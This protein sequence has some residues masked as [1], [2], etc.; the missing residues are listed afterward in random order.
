MSTADHKALIRRMLYEVIVEG[1][2]ALMDE[3]VAPD[4][5]NHNVVGTGEASHSVGVD[6]FRQETRAIR[7]AQSDIAIDVAHLLADGDYVIAHV[8]SRSSHTGEFGGIPPTGK[9]IEVASMSIVRFANGKLAER[10]NLV[11]RYGTLQ[12]LGVIPSQ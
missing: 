6:N 8:R 9:K 4:F 5:V 7:S 3:L 2:L 11:D 12:Q 1:N 10:W